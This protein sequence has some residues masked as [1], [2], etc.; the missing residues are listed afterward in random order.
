MGAGRECA[1]AILQS[2]TPSAPLPMAM[3]PLQQ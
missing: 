1:S 2:A 3:A